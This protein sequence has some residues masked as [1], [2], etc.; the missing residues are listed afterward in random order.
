MKKLFENKIVCRTLIAVISLYVLIAFVK[1][2]PINGDEQ[3]MFSEMVYG[4]A[5]KPFVYRT[6]LPT[7]VRLVSGVIPEEIHNSLTE[8][9]ESNHSLVLVLEKLK[10]ES[11]FI[12]EYLIAMVLMYFSLLGFVYVFRK[13]FDEIYSSHLWFKNLISVILL[14]AIPAMFQPNYS[15]YVYDFPALFL[16][17]LGLLL[18]RQRK[19]NYFLVIFLISC[20]NKE[21]TILLTLIFAIHFYKKDEVTRKF[22]Y[23]FITFQLIIFAAVKI[24]LFILFKN[25]PGGFVEFHLI[26]RN[27][28]LFNG[29][30]LTT[31][32]VLLII[33]L[34][35][36]SRWNEKPKFLKDALWIAIPLVI[37]TFLLGFFDELRDFYEV[38]PVIIL[39]ISLN[40]ARILGVEF[41]VIKD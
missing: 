20:F 16:F 37:L 28:L 30:S 4:T 33:F 8:K 35:I 38:F 1:L 40:I 23:K 11:E 32:V 29:Y 31:F 6:L 34:T 13:L 41:K 3:S 14:L 25:N 26:D 24:L 19:W 17:T 15:N 9:F 27:Y 2:P 10:W 21:T 36:F 39:L 7:T 5:W 22:Y 18:L 12:T